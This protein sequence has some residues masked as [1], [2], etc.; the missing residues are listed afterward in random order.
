MLTHV[1]LTASLAA[2]GSEGKRGVWIKVLL[3]QSEL[4]PPAAKVSGAAD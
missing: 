2:W 4:I 1:D 3:A